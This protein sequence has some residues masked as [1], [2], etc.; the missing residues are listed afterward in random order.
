MRHTRSKAAEDKKLTGIRIEA[1]PDPALPRGGPGRDVYGNFIIT[2][3]QVEVGGQPLKFKRI[4]ADDEPVNPK[5]LGTKQLWTIDA[6]QDEKRLTRHWYS[7]RRH[8]CP[9]RRV[10]RFA[11]VWYR[12]RLQRPDAWAASGCR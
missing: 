7:Y 2:D 4:V 6:S 5:S 10:L 8:R 9:C 11:S 12:I 3:V 1:L